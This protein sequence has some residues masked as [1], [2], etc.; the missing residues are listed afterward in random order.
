MKVSWTTQALK[1]VEHIRR[2]IALDSEY[3]AAI[4][5][6]RILTRVVQLESFPQSGET[7]PEYA[8][9]DIREV[10]VHAFRIIYRISDVEV[11][12]LAVVHGARRLGDLEH[13]SSP[14]HPT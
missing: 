3:Y 4:V 11:H 14:Q 12:I 10:L 13:R 9:D 5:C 1:D 7:V 6:D 8:R 2:H